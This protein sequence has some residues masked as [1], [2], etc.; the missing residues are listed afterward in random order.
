LRR[1]VY[2]TYAQVMAQEPR[3]IGGPRLITEYFKYF[4]ARRGT[5]IFGYLVWFSVAGIETANEARERFDITPPER[6][7]WWRAH[8]DL[9]KFG[10]YLK[11]N[12]WYIEDNDDDIRPFARQLLDALQASRLEKEVQIA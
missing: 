8:R 6:T 4:R 12:G 9:R 5:Q 3:P 7:A 11:R 2:A 1:C 10:E